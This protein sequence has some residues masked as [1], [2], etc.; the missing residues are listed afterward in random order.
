[1]VFIV[2][3]KDSQLNSLLREHPTLERQ[4]AVIGGFVSLY[5][6]L[7]KGAASLLSVRLPFLAHSAYRLVD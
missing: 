3:M 4:I 5:R 6:L 1:M 2:S 7:V